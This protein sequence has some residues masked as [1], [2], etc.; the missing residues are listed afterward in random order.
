[1]LEIPYPKSSIHKE[2]RLLLGT[3]VPLPQKKDDLCTEDK[4]DDG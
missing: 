3:I 4:G 2:K 1:M